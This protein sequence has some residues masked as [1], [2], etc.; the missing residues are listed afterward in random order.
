MNKKIAIIGGGNLGKS[1]ATGLLRANAVRPEDLTITRRKIQFLLSFSE[2]G[3]N[4]TSDN[5]KAV[6]ES[7]IVIFC[8]KPHKINDILSSVKSDILKKKPIVI[9]TVTGVKLT[10]LAGILGS[11]TI[12]LYRA[13][14][15][16][17]ISVGESMTC[18]STNSQDEVQNNTIAGLFNVM[19]HSAFVD[20]DLMGAA[21]VLA[22]SGI[23][24]AMRYIR[25]AMQAG[26][27]I[28]F[29]SELSKQIVTQTVKGAS[30][31]L[32]ENNIHPESEIDKVTTPRG[33][34]ITGLSK[35]ELHGFS[36][37]LVQGVL[38]SFEKIKEVK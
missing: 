4:V 36:A 29:S 21:T 20:D 28:G 18:I 12:S 32:Q 34:T 37:S 31:L 22:A 16:I 3:V 25:A 11:T 30:V 19:G 10:E 17:A 33:I 7:D 8:V 5:H 9:S 6:N 38:A 35:M 23:A 26:I 13:M 24:F 27:E 14:P 15:N 2:Q 1:I